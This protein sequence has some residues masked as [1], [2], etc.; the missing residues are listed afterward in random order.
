MHV[1]VR[2][3][4]SIQLHVYESE[5]LYGHINYGIIKSE[6]FN[7]ALGGPLACIIK[8]FRMA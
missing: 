4:L 3:L 8:P 6:V 5:A 1:C 7:P 2:A